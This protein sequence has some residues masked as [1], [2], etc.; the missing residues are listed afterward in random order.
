M[1]KSLKTWSFNMNTEIKEEW[2]DIKGYE[3]I[4]RVSNY[5]RVKRTPFTQE[6][7]CPQNT[8]VIIKISHKERILKGAPNKRTNHLRVTLSIG[9]KELEK[10]FL[11]HRLVAQ[12]FIPN[13]ENK[14]CINHIDSNPLN[15]H[16]SNLE[17]VTNKENSQHALKNNRLI[18]TASYYVTC[19]ELNLTV[20]GAVEM[21]KK[22]NDL[23]HKVSLSKIVAVIN[24]HRYS[25]A[26]LTFSKQDVTC[27]NEKRKLRLELNYA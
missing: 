8:S 5:G 21:C 14:P 1:S 24:G 7:V 11:V 10:R 19:H 23:G 15:N 2:R 4:Y 20:F 6:L 12:E 9:K 25:H 16:I 22:L 17:W 3:G 26:G 27:P 13:P 18:K